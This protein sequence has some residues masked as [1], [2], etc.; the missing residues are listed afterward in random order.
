M[1][2]RVIAHYAI[3]LLKNTLYRWFIYCIL[4]VYLVGSR[5]NIGLCQRELKRSSKNQVMKVRKYRK[6]W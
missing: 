3:K 6:I 5:L 1:F 2:T 4:M